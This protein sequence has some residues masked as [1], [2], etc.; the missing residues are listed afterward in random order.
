MTFDEAVEQLRKEYEH[1]KKLKHVKNPIAY[2]LYHTWRVADSK[3]E[4]ERN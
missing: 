4:R 2:A 3:K 1:A